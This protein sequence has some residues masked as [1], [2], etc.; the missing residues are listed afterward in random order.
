MYDRRNHAKRLLF[1]GLV[2]GNFAGLFLALVEV[3]FLVAWHGGARTAGA[4]Q[5][6]LLYDALVILLAGPLLGLVCGSLAAVV[7]LLAARLA[8]QRQQEPIWKARFHLVLVMPVAA[9]VANQAFRGP[10]ASR[11][12]AAPLLAVATGLV[13][14]AL[15]YG[16]SRLIVRHGER[17]AVGHSG[18]WMRCLAPPLVL[19]LAVIF[20]LAD[21]LVLPRLYP[22]FHW[23]LAALALFTAWLGIGATHLAFDR[24]RRQGFGQLARPFLA[25]MISCM[26]LVLGLIGNRGVGR[27]N[28]YRTI[29]FERTAF[30]SK[31]LTITDRA[32]I[33]P[34]PPELRP[35]PPPE[36]GRAARQSRPHL[37]GADVVL[38]TVDALRADRI[39]LFGYRRRVGGEPRSITPNID[40]I[41]GKA[42][43]FPRAYCATPKTSY[44]VVSL[45]TGQPVYT[46]ARL[47]E[48]RMWPTL[49]EVLRAQRYRTAGFY[50]LAIF[51]IDSSRFAQYRSGHLGFQYFKFED[52]DLPAKRR[53]DQVIRFLDEHR[54]AKRRE[55]LFVWA[56]YFDP[57]EPYRV[58]AGFH[59]FGSSAEARYDAE[60]AYVDAEIGR[61]LNAVKQRRSRVLI[62]LTADH[63]E[64]FGEH[65][66]ANH[67][68]SVFD[69]QVRVPLLLAG[70]GLPD[71]TVDAPVSLTQ[72]SSTVLRLLGGAVPASM[73]TLPDLTELLV[74]GAGGA[75]A[76]CEVGQ[77]RMLALG[78][79]KLIRD[80]RR[81]YLALYDLRR[82]AGEQRPL[83]VDRDGP[84]RK[85]ASELL[86]HLRA[87]QRRLEQTI[88]RTRR[89]LRWS[90][91][92]LALTAP[93]L[94]R[95]R[96]AASALMR[97]AQ[98][99]GLNPEMMEAARKARGD[100]DPE[101]RHRAQIALAAHAGRTGGSVDVGVLQGL[102]SR[103]DLPD[104]MR[105]TA[106]LALAA[107]RDHGALPPLEELLPRLT[108][109]D[110]RIE[111]IR[112]LGQL[113]GA[114]PRSIE[115]LVA[116][117]EDHEVA[118]AV[119]RAFRSLCRSPVAA[120]FVR[121][122]VLPLF[123]LLAR[124]PEHMGQR[125]EILATLACIGT[126][127]AM[128]LL[129]DWLPREREQSVRSV[130]LA[131]LARLLA[132]WGRTL[133]GL[134][135]GLPGAG[136]TGPAG[137]CLAGR[138]C[139]L[140]AAPVTLTLEP[141]RDRVGRAAT[142]WVVEE[143]IS[144]AGPEVRIDGVIL[145]RGRAVPVHVG[146]MGQIGHT[147]E[148]G[149]PCEHQGPL[150][151]RTWRFALPAGQLKSRVEV[152]LRD[153]TGGGTVVR[154]VALLPMTEEPSGTAPRG[155]P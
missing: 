106:G 118:V 39:G 45:L 112:A 27:S 34:R 40:R 96:S 130:G 135:W 10:W 152:Q 83:D 15:T 131:L 68:T 46:L 35:T 132:R 124:R 146:Q 90:A 138:G 24:L 84:D 73:S 85:R 17:L 3:V 11:L 99:K 31:V 136:I 88:R 18:K 128:T 59:G 137:A 62:V 149:A 129:G 20:Y 7:H 61:L 109:T 5:K 97:R 78:H 153:P 104:D 60:V 113:G 142:L 127:R 13:L 12:P 80:A 111:V 51:T 119:L 74:R 52:E 21:V 122:A 117:A 105:L 29:V 86:G 151:L 23:S 115:V 95:R 75:G 25:G 125:S 143:G 94:E 33:L 58:R 67:G 134:A 44:S 28:V 19:A 76:M 16:A 47:G 89:S 145:R 6:V 66:G 56:H 53:T 147:G 9:Y 110:S 8:N 150:P 93:D 102:L 38:I 69:E 155:Q 2:L 120:P 64:E 22:F 72:V 126:E 79:H 141:G 1:G 98:R 103:P 87:Q 107:A 101:V 92:A 48:H 37:R 133:P 121:D 4:P 154:L 41:F 123:R 71:R 55:P 70:P 30:G 54:L 43:R 91:L 26:A 36:R 65:G 63:G 148:T 77:H 100:V 81:G 32:K 42:T 144:K 50:P 114:S 116:A 57:H 139:R 49:P 82:D 108:S 14:L 140:E